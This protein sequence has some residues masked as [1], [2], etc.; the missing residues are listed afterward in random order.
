M[1]SEELLN[2]IYL[3]Y[4]GWP[5][6][7]LHPKKKISAKDALIELI[8]YAK[9]EGCKEQRKICLEKCRQNFDPIFF[10]TNIYKEIEK[11]ILNAPEPE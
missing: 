4:H 7:G 9:S 1:K 6:S 11:S 2:E 5:P 10:T 3:C 8:Q